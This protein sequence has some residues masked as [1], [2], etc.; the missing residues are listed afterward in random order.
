ME[1]IE[2]RVLD[3]VGIKVFVLMVLGV[4]IFDER[5]KKWKIDYDLN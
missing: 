2:E 5:I 3:Y 4:F 1:T